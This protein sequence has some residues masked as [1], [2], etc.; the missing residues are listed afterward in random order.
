MKTI[1]ITIYSHILSIV[2]SIKKNHPLVYKFI[3][4]LTLSWLYALSSNILIPLPFNP[5][6][7]TLQTITL[8]CCAN[9]FGWPALHAYLLY[10][11]QGFCGA[12]FFSH[13]GHGLTHLLGPT[14][15]Y[16]IGFGAGMFFLVVTKN[17]I[18]RWPRLF[19][20]V[21]YLIATIIMFTC[22]LTQLALFVG[23]GKILC[24]GLYPFLLVDF[25][26]K[27]IIAL[28]IFPKNAPNN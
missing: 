3:C 14:G 23:Q 25:I 21:K 4:A 22:G 28:Y 16:I 27:P 12:P 19:F 1:T 2:L 17:I 26:I 18:T 9:I 11:A 20:I 8:F 5:V 6:P 24:L 7:I 15:G 13:G 10:L